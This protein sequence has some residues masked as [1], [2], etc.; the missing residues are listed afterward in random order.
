MGPAGET[1][2]GAGVRTVGW[3]DKGRSVGPLVGLVGW[4]VGGLGK[5]RE[6]KGVR[7]VS[8]ITGETPCLLY[9]C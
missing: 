6:G 7:G 2:E 1:Q 9:N 3:E 4:S 8:L 5:E